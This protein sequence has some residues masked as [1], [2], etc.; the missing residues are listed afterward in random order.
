[1][2]YYSDRNLSLCS[3]SIMIQVHL[4]AVRAKYALFIGLYIFVSMDSLGNWDQTWERVFDIDC[5]REQKALHM[6]GDNTAKVKVKEKVLALLPFC[7][8]SHYPEW[9]IGIPLQEKNCELIVYTKKCIVL[10]NQGN[11]AFDYIES[12]SYLSYLCIHFPEI[13]LYHSCFPIQS[14]VG[15]MKIAER[16]ICW[17]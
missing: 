2:K 6:S 4:P 8:H 3:Y 7:D 10:I 16:D 17:C 13:C 15:W 9:F 11:E 5:A 1:M 12:L 14:L